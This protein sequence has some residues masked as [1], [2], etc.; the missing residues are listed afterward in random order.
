[1]K[2]PG[3]PASLEFITCCFQSQLHLCGFR[4]TSPPAGLPARPLA[5]PVAK[6][7]T[8]VFLDS[9]TLVIVKSSRL[10]A[11]PP[12]VCQRTGSWG[13]GF[14]WKISVRNRK[15]KYLLSMRKTTNY[16]P[17]FIGV[18]LSSPV[19]KYICPKCVELRGYSRCCQ[20]P[21]CLPLSFFFSADRL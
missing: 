17:E 18:F 12:S 11:P 2:Y 6:S 1:M 16:C 13:Q 20:I 8:W 5:K 14:I 10:P 3:F 9:V 15:L 7:H 21:I 19:K 4:S